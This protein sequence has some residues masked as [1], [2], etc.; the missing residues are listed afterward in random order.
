LAATTRV[1]MISLTFIGL[2]PDDVLRD[3]PRPS[4]FRAFHR[5]GREDY[6]NLVKKK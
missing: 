4:R 3:V 5:K 2:P 1:S 6:V